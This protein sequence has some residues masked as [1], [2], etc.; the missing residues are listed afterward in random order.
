MMTFRSF[1]SEGFA[2]GRTVTS[3]NCRDGKE[4]ELIS[5]FRP[6]ST[7]KLRALPHFHTRPIDL[8]VY[9]GSF[10]YA[11]ISYLEAGFPLRCF[12]RLS[13]PNV[14]TLLCHWHDN[15]DTRGSSIPVLSY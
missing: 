7:G 12:Q 13:L 4:E 9:K 3:F 8:V 2:F 10:T 11:R 5:S 15:R 6:I 1:G 14:A